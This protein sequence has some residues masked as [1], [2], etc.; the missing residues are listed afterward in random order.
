MKL[1]GTTRNLN[2]KSSV[3]LC[4]DLSDISALMAKN[5][6]CG[7]YTES[8]T[9]LCATGV[10]ELVRVPTRYGHKATS[11]LNRSAIAPGGVPLT[12]LPPR[13]EPTVRSRPVTAGERRLP[14]LVKLGESLGLGFAGIKTVA[15]EVLVEEGTQHLLSLGTEEDLSLDVV[16]CGLVTPGR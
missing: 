5:Y 12:W 3:P 8:G 15:L 9:N 11:P 7:F 10:A 2:R 4:I 14:A 13:I 1:P 6:L 16:V